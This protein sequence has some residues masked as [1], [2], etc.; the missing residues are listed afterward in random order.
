MRQSDLQKTKS[1]T[2]GSF[3]Y[4]VFCSVMNQNISICVFF[5]TSKIALVSGKLF[6]HSGKKKHV[7]Y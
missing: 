2:I 7:L 5:H 4:C 1:N 6:G 3:N